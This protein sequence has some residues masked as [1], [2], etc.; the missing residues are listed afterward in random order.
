MVVDEVHRKSIGHPWLT[1]GMDICTRMI[2]GFYLS[3]DAPSETSVGM[4]IAQG[5]L[6]KESYLAQHGIEGSWP[7]CG[8]PQTLH[9]DNGPDFRSRGLERSCI[10]HG[11]NITFRPVK[12][13]H[14]GGHIERVL[15]TVSRAIHKIPGST[16][17]SPKDR[18][19]YDSEK[20]ACMTIAE[21][22]AWLLSWIVN[23][24]HAS[25]HKT[26]EMSP[27]QK[28][29]IGINGRDGIPGIGQPTLPGDAQTA[30]ISFL[31]HF[32]R[33]IQRQGVSIDGLTYFDDVLRPWVGRDDKTTKQ[34]QKFIFRRDPRDVRVVWFHDPSAK[35]YF[36]LR[37]RDTGLPSFSAWELER[38]KEQLKND[39]LN[40]QNSSQLKRAL[41]H[42]RARVDEAKEKTK[43]ARREESKR[44]EHEKK[45]IKAAKDPTSAR[46]AASEPE[47]PL[48]GLVSGDLGVL[49]DVE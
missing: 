42:R 45:A 37:L 44:R 13:A 8:Y 17:S 14:Y 40:S 2:T 28:W 31:P 39:G 16:F 26:L 1:L 30:Y 36:K 25:K 38:I 47:P 22:E 43:V 23:T 10:E 35:E 46:P 33:T 9:V 20:N 4:C 6:P 5:A 7:V 21:L 49:G 29:D 19:N 15:G 11:I 32:S 27:L 48:A 41:L 18:G 24:Y 34:R 12:K 3:F